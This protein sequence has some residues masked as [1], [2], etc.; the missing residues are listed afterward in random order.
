M[1]DWENKRFP[2]ALPD[3]AVKML[4]RDPESGACSTI[5]RL[6]KGWT[7]DR[8]DRLGASFEALVLEGTFTLNGHTFIEDCYGYLPAGHER[9]GF[10]TETGAVV[11]G[12]FGAEPT[13]AEKDIPHKDD[14]IPFLNLHDMDWERADIDPDV[15]FLNLSHKTLRKN[16]ETGDKT[17]LLQMGAHT[18]PKGWKERQLYHPC[19]EEMYLLTGDIISDVGI[20]EAG[21][22]FWRPPNLMHGPF[23]A[24]KGGLAVIRFHDG[25][26]VNLWGEEELPFDLTPA[27]KPYLP[28]ELEDLAS[29]P[30]SPAP[31]Y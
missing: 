7:L 10:A 1:L 25:H 21:A 11:L 29:K 3:V 22:Y 13:L 27:Y 5:L 23:G 15:Q 26:H 28:D 12:F 8:D 19:V 6:P 4:S 9:R 2:E 31:N 16:K 14:T 30:W 18:H 17:L 20:M 24:R